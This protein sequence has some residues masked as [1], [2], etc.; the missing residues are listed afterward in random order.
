MKKQKKRKKRKPKKLT[1]QALTN[2]LD[3]TVREIM[4]IETFNPVCF[5]CGKH[6]GWFHPQKNRFGCQTGHYISRQKFATCWD[7]KNVWPQCIKCNYNHN[8]NSAPFA[9]RI[10]EVHGIQRIEYL[11]KQCKAYTGFT[12]L[13]RREILENLLEIKRQ[14]IID[15]PPVR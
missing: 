4:R 10:I 9:L 15:N 12:T 2:K 8:L 14:A 1:G 6:P 11:D 3:D 13:E 7:L 5:V